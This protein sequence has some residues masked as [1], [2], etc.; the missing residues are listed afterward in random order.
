MSLNSS[1]QFR[2]EDS[3]VGA[4]DV[5]RANEGRCKQTVIAVYGFVNNV[6]CFLLP[7]ANI[8]PNCFLY[9]ELALTCEIHVWFLSVPKKGRRHWEKL[10]Y[11]EKS[12]LEIGFQGICKIWPARD[13]DH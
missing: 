5:L 9:F 6:D 11:A 7:R 4:V 1:L 10:D 13:R 8:T 12:L 3:T 2:S